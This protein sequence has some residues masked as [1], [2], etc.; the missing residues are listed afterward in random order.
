MQKLGH[1]SVI[2]E[3][4]DVKNVVVVRSGEAPAVIP[5]TESPIVIVSVCGVIPIKKS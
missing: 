5:F 2:H 4:R 3:F 1:F